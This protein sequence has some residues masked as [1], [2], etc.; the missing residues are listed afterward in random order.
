ML[1]L[2]CSLQVQYGLKADLLTMEM[3]G[4]QTYYI[5]NSTGYTVAPFTN[6]YYLSPSLHHVL[7]QGLQP[8]T[9]YFYK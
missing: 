9:V 5:T 8:N 4:Q 7:L 2:A 3:E 6:N 1:D